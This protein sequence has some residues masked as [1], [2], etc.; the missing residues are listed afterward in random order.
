[1]SRIE[2]DIPALADMAQQLMAL[3]EEFSAIED[4]VDGFEEAVGS[5]EISD[6]LHSFATNW[7][8]EKEEL[9]EKMEQVAGYADAAAQAYGG[10]ES[11]ISG[12]LEGQGG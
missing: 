1:M 5:E 6:K 10:I 3:K 11:E 8:D 9:G 4:V 2:V 12:H 7:S